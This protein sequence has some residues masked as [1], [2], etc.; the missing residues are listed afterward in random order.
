MLLGFAAELEVC[1]A[2]LDGFFPDGVFGFVNIA[3]GGTG[4]A[5]FFE[6]FLLILSVFAAVLVAIILAIV[7]LEALVF[8]PTFAVVAFAVVFVLVAA[9]GALLVFLA[10]AVDL[11]PL[12]FGCE[13]LVVL[14]APVELL[15][16][17]ED[18]LD[19][20]AEE[21]LV[22]LLLLL[23]DDDLPDFEPEDFLPGM[24]IRFQVMDNWMHLMLTWPI[25]FYHRREFL[26]TWG[27]WLA[28]CGGSCRLALPGHV[29]VGR[30]R[31]G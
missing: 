1:F 20:E 26:G 17:A 10:V 28:R 31:R 8:T 7:C 21:P 27:S 13:D 25:S 6:I 9:F 11:L 5:A 16:E 23:L 2:A 22:P 14:L 3:L 24:V 12:D 4:M 29:G 15:L 18:L 30:G 19:F